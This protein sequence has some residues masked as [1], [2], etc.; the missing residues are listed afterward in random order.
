VATG[1]T[2]R[3]RIY[4]GTWNALLRQVDQ[5]RASVLA[6]RKQGLPAEWR[7]PRW[8]SP[9]TIT[10]DRGGFRVVNRGKPWW[11][12][13]TRLA[14]G[15]AKFSAKCGNWHAITDDAALR[16]LKLTRR[17]NGHWWEHSVS[18]A[19]DGMPEA[20]HAGTG[21]V[22]LDWGHREHGHPGA[23]RGMRVF[24]WL[25]DDGMNGEI[26]LPREC[27]EQKDREDEIRAQLDSAFAA[28]KKTL[29]L[30]A[31]TR[32]SYRRQLM[33][34]GV[35]TEDELRW[36]TWEMRYERRAAKARKRWQNIRRETYLQA[37]RDLRTAY[38]TFAIEDE[39]IAGKTGRGGHRR[40]AIEEQTAH[41]KRS[42]RELSARYEFLQLCERSGAA[43][44]PVTSRNSTREC[45][46][47][48]QLHENGP[49]LYRVCPKTG[50]VDDKDEAA[51][52][53]ILARARAALAKRVA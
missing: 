44:L 26:L 41:R 53:T 11:T 51:C 34:A 52:E 30:K 1:A 16:T 15:W 17:K 21:L 48:G 33:R 2:E 32:Q 49:E 35:R 29:S 10:A 14:N 7:R 19:V 22:A 38:G 4:W 47:C 45:P 5:A 3:S 12:I 31:R 9:L 39:T 8:D 13:E 18:I 27:R 24:T 40:T 46:Q 20:E 23:L 37:I 28:R 6:R 42:N 43:I 36:L 25:G 50:I